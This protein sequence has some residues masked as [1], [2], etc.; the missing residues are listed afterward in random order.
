MPLP[1]KVLRRSRLLIRPDTVLANTLNT[2][3]GRTGELI[4]I[5]Q[6]LQVVHRGGHPE[7]APMLKH[8]TEHL[9]GVPVPVP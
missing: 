2:P 4:A 9:T 6:L 5:A 7:L 8:H 1:R 3:A